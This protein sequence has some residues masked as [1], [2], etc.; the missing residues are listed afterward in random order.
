MFDQLGRKFSFFS[1]RGFTLLEISIVMLIFGV[2]AFAVFP[3]V[4]RA[5][6]CFRLKVAADK[7][8]TDIRE[9]QQCALSEESPCFYIQFFPSS[10]H[11]EVRKTAYPMY[12]VMS[13]VNFPATVDLVDT[14]FDGEKLAVSAKGTPSPR[15]GT[16][17][18]R[19]TVSG[20]F[21][22]VIITL[23]TGRVRISDH[24]PESWKTS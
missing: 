12:V 7:L 5:L 20:K 9:L 22:Y 24:P 4:N 18:L 16:V 1:S 21:K 17:T 13:R 23:I 2:F 6:A 8:V 3:E 11:Y 10:E 14:N 19:E 15:G